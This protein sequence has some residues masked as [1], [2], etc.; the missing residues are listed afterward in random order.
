MWNVVKYP[1]YLSPISSPFIS[2]SNLDP[3]LGSKLDQALIITIPE[4]LWQKFSLAMVAIIIT[5]SIS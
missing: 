4:K 1:L 3:D 5:S 2:L